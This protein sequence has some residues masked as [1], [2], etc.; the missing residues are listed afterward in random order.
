ML[1]FYAV[2]NV[3]RKQQSKSDSAALLGEGSSHYNLMSNCRMN[4]L[5]KYLHGVFLQ[6]KL[7]SL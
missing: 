7:K 1:Y 2:V 4:L 3:F 5:E 6:G